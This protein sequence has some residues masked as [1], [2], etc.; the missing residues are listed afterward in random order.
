MENG[1]AVGIVVLNIGILV[2]CL[3]MKLKFIATK[4]AG[5]RALNNCNVVK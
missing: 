2:K 5:E 3:S 4:K 1:F